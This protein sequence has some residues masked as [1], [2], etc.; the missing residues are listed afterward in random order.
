MLLGPLRHRF[1]ALER[2][3]EQGI[4]HY[5]VPRYSRIV[6]NVESKENINKAYSLISTS[7][8]RNEMIVKDVIAC[9]A[10]KQTPVIL[11][12][13]KEH[14]KLLYHTLKNEADHVFLLYGDNSDRENADIRVR[15]K[16]IP[17]NETLILVATGQK[18]AIFDSGNYTEKFEQ[19]IV[20]AEK[21]VV[22]SSPDIRQDKIE[23][24]LFLMKGRQEAGVK[25]TVITTDPEEVV[26]GSSD[27][28][29]ELIRMMRQVGINVVIKQEVEERFVIIDDELVWHGGMNLLGKVDVW[30]NLMRI[31]NHQVAAELMEIALGSEL[32]SQGDKY[33]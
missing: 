9:V 33:L 32:E 17:Q 25:A 5:F 15:L 16:Q 3:Q 7:K 11:T 12:R 4:G 2:A 23:R 24:F 29:H 10:R 14:A 20:E 21:M 6:D 1:T 8:V 18:N 31:K 13:F 30:D 27:V 26:Y 22:I 19:D 28:C